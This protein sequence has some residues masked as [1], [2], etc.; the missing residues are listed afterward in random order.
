MGYIDSAKKEGA[1]LECGGEQF[2]ER[3]YFIRPTVFSGV[4]D[5][6]KIAREEVK[7]FDHLFIDLI[8]SNL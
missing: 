4:T 3:G 7:D 5:S 8:F 1:K 6:M 2:G